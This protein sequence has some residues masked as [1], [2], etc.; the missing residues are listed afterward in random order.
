MDRKIIHLPLEAGLTAGTAILGDPSFSETPFDVPDPAVLY[1]F[2]CDLFPNDD[3]PL[4]VAMPDVNTGKPTEIILLI[5]LLIYINK[6][7]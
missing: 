2:A 1:L 7:I 6:I 3:R 5:L 4:E